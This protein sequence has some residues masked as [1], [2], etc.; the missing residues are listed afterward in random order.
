MSSIELIF[1]QA[2]P[3]VDE[4]REHLREAMTRLGRAAVWTEWERTA[5]NAPAYVRGYASPSVLV[6]GR[7]VAGCTPLDAGSG[8]RIY[9]DPGGVLVPAPTAPMILAALSAADGVREGIASPSDASPAHAPTRGGTS[10]AAKPSLLAAGAA[11]GGL[12]SA[13]VA[14]LAGLCCAGPITVL[15]LGAGGAVAAAGLA[16]YRLPL[17]LVSGLL[18]FG[19]YWRVYR[20]RSAGPACSIGVGRWMRMSL[21]IASIAW[22]A[23]AA[24]WVIER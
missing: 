17:L 14:A 6:A 18:I 22:I 11:I 9:V 7:D 24:L 16:P 13:S 23:G 1:D 5:P 2:C 8:C 15:L 12:A 4:A 21:T 10:A 19:G 20:A 3:H